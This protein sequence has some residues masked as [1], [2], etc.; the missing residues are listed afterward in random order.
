[1]TERMPGILAGIA[2]FTVSF[3]LIFAIGS[4]LFLIT[5]PII[6]AVLIGRL[7]QRRDREER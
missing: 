3:V 1:M 4:P 5:I 2:T 6:L 7:A